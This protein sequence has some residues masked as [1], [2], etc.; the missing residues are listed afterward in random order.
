V[1]SE[2]IAFIRRCRS[3]LLT[4]WWTQKEKSEK[5]EGQGE[6]EAQRAADPKST[7]YMYKFS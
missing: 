3:S 7:N 2:A 6:G 1:K 4:G 5:M